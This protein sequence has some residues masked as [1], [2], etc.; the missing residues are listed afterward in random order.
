MEIILFF[1]TMGVVSGCSFTIAWVTARLA[2]RAVFALARV[3]DSG[4]RI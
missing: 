2:L 3:H 4:P 1:V